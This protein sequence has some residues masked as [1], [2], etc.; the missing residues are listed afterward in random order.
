MTNPT[1]LWSDAA[2]RELIAWGKSFHSPYKPDVEWNVWQLALAAE[3]L[4]AE[5]VAAPPVPCLS[6]PQPQLETA[7]G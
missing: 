6:H 4:L 5:Q 2:L 3:A 1:P 7:H